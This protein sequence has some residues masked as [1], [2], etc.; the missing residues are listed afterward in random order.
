MAPPASDLQP[1]DPA[2]DPLL[3][4]F[5][6]KHLRLKKLGESRGLLAA[7]LG[8]ATTGQEKGT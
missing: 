8:F 3:Q 7:A 5:E 4:P 1:I 6:L 2:K